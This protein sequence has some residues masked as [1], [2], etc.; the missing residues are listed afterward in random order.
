MLP[1]ATFDKFAP[2]LV[3]H[4]VPVASPVGTGMPDGTDAT[5]DE[6][7]SEEEP[8]AQQLA[9]EEQSH[10]LPEAYRRKSAGGGEYAVP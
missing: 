2:L 3:G 6:K 4:V 7:E 5:A 1:V 10:T 8:A 9:E